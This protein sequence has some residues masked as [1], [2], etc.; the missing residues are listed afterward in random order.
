MDSYRDIKKGSIDRQ[1]VRKTSKERYTD[2]YRDIKTK[3]NRQLQ[4]HIHK[5]RKTVTN[6]SRQNIQIATET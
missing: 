3:T 2:N 1:I 5:A 4:R 6:T